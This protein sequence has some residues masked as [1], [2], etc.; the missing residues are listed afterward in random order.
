MDQSCHAEYNTNM[1]LGN[2]ICRRCGDGFSAT[3]QIVNSNGE[4]WHT[5]CFVNGSSEPRGA[6]CSK[7]GEDIEAQ[8]QMVN[9]HGQVWHPSCFVCA[10]CFQPFPEGIFYEYEGRKYCEHD[11][12]VLFAP[13]CGSCGEFII[14][15]VIKA[16]NNSWHPDCF[17][18]ELCTGPLADAG[19]VKNA[20]RALCRECN[21]KEKAKGLG[22]YVCHK[23]HSIIEEGHIK[24]KGEAYHPYHFNCHSCGQELQSDAREKGS[25]LYCLR[26]HDKMGIP[27]C[28]A[29]RRPIEERVV[30]ALGK[31]WHVEHFVCAKCEKPFL[32]TRHYEKKG[33]AYCELHYHQLFGNICFVCNNIIN[34]DVFSAFNKAWCV[35]HFACSICDRKMSQKTKFFE[36]DLKPVCKFCYDRFPGELK[37]RLKKA[38]DEAAKK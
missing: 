25:E 28:G 18:C 3:E 27:I 1:S 10:Q 14:G 5:Q 9:Y 33:L 8:E 6:M 30:H 34:G 36:F 11:F 37:K 16:M 24:F 23:C 35:N 29:C 12:H 22:K 2:A 13:C 38:Y 21:A 31:S 26:C 15:R 17:R 20:N 32:G 19:F 7:C 4:V